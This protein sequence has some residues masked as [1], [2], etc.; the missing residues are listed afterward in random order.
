MTLKDVMK[1]LENELN[2]STLV[3]IYES[4]ELEIIGN[5]SGYVYFS[6]HRHTKDE[7]ILHI[8]EIE[9]SKELYSEV[10]NVN[11][12]FNIINDYSTILSLDYL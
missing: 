8:D 9:T 6:I 12:V 11:E 5:F 4:S 10:T 7:V 3:N 2:K 1:N